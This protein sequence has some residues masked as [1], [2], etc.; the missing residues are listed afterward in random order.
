M[1]DPQA[2]LTKEDLAWLGGLIDGEGCIYLARRIRGKSKGDGKNMT[3]NYKPG[4]S[5][6]NSDPFI[7]EEAHRILTLAGLGHW[8]MWMNPR[9]HAGRPQTKRMMGSVQCV[10]FKRTQKALKILMPYV[11]AKRDQAQI[12]LEFVERRL[13]IKPTSHNT[14]NEVDEEYHR[15]LHQLKE[16]GASET[17]RG[18]RYQ[19]FPDDGKI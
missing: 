17:I 3:T 10:G 12:L 16:K 1:D 14:Y 9:N 15:R 4:I 18:G 8:I 2:T 19:S 6:A 7:I 5:I 11:R 13:A